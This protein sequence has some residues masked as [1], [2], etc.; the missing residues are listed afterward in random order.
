M[1]QYWITERATA[2]ARRR[3]H[4]GPKGANSDDGATSIGGKH[5]RLAGGVARRRSPVTVGAG[6]V[7]DVEN[8]AIGEL[9][10]ELRAAGVD[11]VDE[12]V[13]AAR[14]VFDSG[15]WRDRFTR[16]DCL[17]GL[18]DLVEHHR[19]E[20]TRS[21]SPKSA[22]RLRCARALQVA[23]PIAM[24]RYFA[25]L[26]VVDRTRFLGRSPDAPHSEAVIKYQPC[27][28]VA[29][30]T[31]YN[32]PLLFAAVKL[33]AALAAG[34][35]AVLLPS[36]QTPLATLFL[37]QLCGKAGFPDGVVNIVA[38]DAECARALTSH[39]WLT[40]SPSPVPPR[41]AAKS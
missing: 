6:G 14:R 16:R 2:A 12:A 15:V 4:Q 23:E 31:A 36:F 33:G 41:S 10:A 1:T 24:L 40:R 28:V 5:H 35:T 17:L 30:V 11:Q 18:A 26:A 34:C 39:P 19:S 21:S 25:E 3:D 7:I 22:R 8:P 13:L 38:G 29:A 27:G 32:Y 9:V 20:L 37:A